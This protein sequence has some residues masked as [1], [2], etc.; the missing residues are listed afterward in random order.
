[1]DSDNIGCKYQLKL[2]SLTFILITYKMNIMENQDQLYSP[3]TEILRSS[4][5]RSSHGDKEEQLLLQ[6]FP[7]TECLATPSKARD[8]LDAEL[9]A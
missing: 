5:G 1:M 2:K 7:N 4:V 8:D 9:A 6:C 3:G